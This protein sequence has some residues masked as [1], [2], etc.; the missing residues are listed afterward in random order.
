MRW[1]HYLAY[2]FAGAFLTN[3][4]PHLING[5]SGNP[6]QSPFATPPGIGLSSALVNVYW[7]LF[8]L[9][10]GYLL[11]FRVGR[12]DLRDTKHALVFGAGIAAM[13]VML[14]HAFAPLHGG[15]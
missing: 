5:L 7:G 12:F 14:A 4:L 9:A 10:I 2:F 15:L 1:H 6:F 13:S 8:N 3:T 11:T